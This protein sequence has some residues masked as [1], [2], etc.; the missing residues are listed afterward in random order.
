FVF[1]LAEEDR[2]L[3]SVA[4]GGGSAAL[5]MVATVAPPP[6]AAPRA[7]RYDAGL[8]GTW[9]WRPNRIGLD[10]FLQDVVPQ[11][12]E[13]MS[14]A[15]AGRMPAGLSS[16]DPRVTF[17]GPVDDAAAFVRSARVIPLI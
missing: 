13:G 5:P 17:L 14:I 9:T 1:T 2:R 8:I 11:L 7:I 15:V 10:W 4:G 6:A 3:L 16:R 12:D